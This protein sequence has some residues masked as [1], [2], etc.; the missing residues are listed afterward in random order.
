MQPFDYHVFAHTDGRYATLA[1]SDTVTAGERLQL[2]QFL[3][4]QTNDRK[5]LDSLQRDPGV[6]WR[7]VSNN[8][9]AL[10]RV[11]E[12]PADASGRATLRF[13]SI[14]VPIGSA[15]EIAR[16]LAG[17]I[18]GDWTIEAGR[19][20]VQPSDELPPLH[21]EAVG[22]ALLAINNE[23]RFVR[24]A[25]GLSITDVQEIA[26]RVSNNTG[27]SIAYRCLNQQAPLTITLFEGAAG[28]TGPTA[29]TEHLMPRTPSMKTHS[30][31]RPHSSREPMSAS[32]SFLL[33]LILA[34]SIIVNLAMFARSTESSPAQLS[35]DLQS[36]ILNPL[37]RR[38]EK[39]E[40][41]IEELRAG[42]EQRTGELR[43]AIE[44]GIQKVGENV[45]VSSEE[46]REAVA[47]DNKS[48]R[49]D[50]IEQ[51][52]QQLGA[53]T[54]T[55]L[56]RMDDLDRAARDR[57]AVIRLE[58]TDIKAQ[59][60]VLDD[61]VRRLAPCGMIAD[62]DRLWTQLQ[63]SKWADDVQQ[64]IDKLRAVCQPAG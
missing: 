59:L 45:N 49:A 47:A 7:P 38:I 21:S 5:Y 37:I 55:V 56:A 62:L 48:G 43:K 31:K 1:C 50:M 11:R 17:I 28:G 23:S 44:E 14:V 3:F 60:S 13:E 2:E 25:T 10:T 12:G 52:R 33:W 61:V 39:L 42:D 46:T 53:D 15:G 19:A 40:K 18:L 24:C 63:K 8:R 32:Y 22:E 9:Y 58:F 64:M 41:A 20:V 54:N 35:S 26:K 6:L 16:D 34:C 4:G 29:R 30:G 36:G 27:F 57:D 51:I